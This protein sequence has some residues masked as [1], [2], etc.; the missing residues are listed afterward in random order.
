MSEDIRRSGDEPRLSPE[1][2]AAR[3]TMARVPDGS[4]AR[5][6]LFILVI[7]YIINFVDRQ[8]LT[9]LAE[10]I[11]ADL[12]I[13]DARIGFLYGT[14]FAVFYALFGIPLAR[15]A[16]VWI[17]TRLIA[18]GLAFWSIM[19]VLSGTARSFEPLAA[20]RFGVG[21]GE[22]SASPAANSLISDYFPAKMRA[23]AISIYCSAICIG[24]GIGIFLGGAIV[25]GWAAMFPDP[26][27]APF[28][29]KGWHVAFFVVGLPGL[30]MVPIVARLREPQR[31]QS[32]GIVVPN[33]P[34]PFQ[35]A[36]RSLIS[37]VPPLTLIGLY[38]AG[39]RVREFAVNG[40][41]AIGLALIAWGLTA[42]VGEPQQWAAL[43]IGIYAVFSWAQALTKRDRVTFQLTFGSRAF[44]LT[45]VG[46]SCIAFATNGVGFWMIPF[47]IRAHDV[48]LAEV[49]SIVG[50]GQAIGGWAGMTLGGIIT[51]RLRPRVNGAPH[52]IGI[53]TGAVCLPIVLSFLTTGNLWVAYVMSFLFSTIAPMYAGPGNT[54]LMELVLPR[55][56]AIAIA[57]H[58][59]TSTFFAFAIGPFVVGRLSDAFIAAGA[60]P[61]DGLRRAMMIG[62]CMLAVAFTLLWLAR[63]FLA[64]DTAK[65]IAR[66]RA[67]GEVI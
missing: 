58:F 10:E 52:L 5:Y 54:A 46:F 39:G 31:G 32:D 65:I 16:D 29:L 35:E 4:Y 2:A 11:K 21:I 53:V 18:I 1:R 33:H 49:G 28:G 15:L 3:T 27:T 19:T 34:T 60:S 66:A 17:R 48:S 20:C 43:A 45:T 41:A 67:A 37:I 40:C 25:D 50:L 12:G 24:S 51:D 8:I 38:E 64:G 26:A 55:M 9:V 6:A 42:Y 56:R 22:A 7:V 63:I 57:L 44:L 30:L 13:S 61:A 47:L 36:G 23:T 62:F 14:A 59:F